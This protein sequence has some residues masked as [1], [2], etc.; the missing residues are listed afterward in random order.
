VRYHRAEKAA[1]ASALRRLASQVKTTRRYDV[2]KIA[3][4]E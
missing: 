1:S 4:E 3:K 2:R